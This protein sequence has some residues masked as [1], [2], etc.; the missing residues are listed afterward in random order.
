MG[1]MRLVRS[2]PRPAVMG[3]EGEKQVRTYWSV[4]ISEM[5]RLLAS[6]T[7][8]RVEQFSFLL[9]ILSLLVLPLFL[10]KLA[11]KNLISFPFIHSVLRFWYTQEGM[12]Q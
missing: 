9:F 4:N 7:R 8:G 12:L 3:E 2:G 5:K 6:V 11:S 1:I 10:T